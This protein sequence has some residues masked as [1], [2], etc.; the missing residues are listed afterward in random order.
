MGFEEDRKL[1][2]GIYYFCNSLMT[3]GV[4]IATAYIKI[5]FGIEMPNI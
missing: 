1:N 4:N 2:M 3:P 5:P